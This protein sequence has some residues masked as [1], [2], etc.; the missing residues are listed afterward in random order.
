MVIIGVV[1]GG[2][3]GFFRMKTGF[4]GFI[5]VGLGFLFFDEKV[6]LGMVFRLMVFRR[7]GLGFRLCWD[8]DEW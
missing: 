1:V 2:G 7:D 4:L 5:G 8:T 3:L 6:N